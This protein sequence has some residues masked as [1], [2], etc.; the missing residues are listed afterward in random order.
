MP[1]EFLARKGRKARNKQSDPDPL[2][3]SEK[4]EKRNKRKQQAEMGE[5]SEMDQLKKIK[6][7]E[8]ADPS[9]NMIDFT[10]ESD[11]KVAKMQ[12]QSKKAKKVEQ[13]IADYASDEEQNEPETE[14]AEDD[15]FDKDLLESAEQ[16]DFPFGS[17]EDDIREAHFDKDGS[18]SEAS[19]IVNEEEDEEDLISDEDHQGDDL[20]TNI[21]AKQTT[22]FPSGQTVEKDVNVAP[23]IAIVQTRIQEVLQILKNFKQRRDPELSRDDYMNQLTEDMCLYYGYSEYLMRKLLDLFPPM[24]CSTFLEANEVPRPVTI[25]TNTLKTRRRDLAQALIQRGV[26]LDPV[27]KWSKVGLTVFDSAV[28]IGATPEYM[29]G[30]YMLQAASS[31]LPVMAL[32]PQENERIL[33]MAS[34]PGGKTTYIG[35]LMRNTGCIFANDANKDRCKGLTANVHR[36]GLTNV[37]VCNHDGRKFPGVIGGFDRVLLDAPCSGTGV[38][39]KDPAV[40][41][42]KTEE[43]FRLLSHLQK[44]LILAAIDSVDANSKTG[45]YIVYSTCSIMVEENE[46]VVSYALRRRPNIK[47]VSTGLEFGEEGFANFRGRVF[48]PSLN[49]TRRYYPHTH[50]MDGFFVAKFKKMSNTVPATA[51][52]K[53]VRESQN[54]ENVVEAEEPE[55][56]EEEDQQFMREAMDSKKRRRDRQH[57]I[58]RKPK[59][60]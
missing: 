4:R 17:D 56:N 5:N 52:S 3:P 58:K 47:L 27:G 49:L 25:R 9:G 13:R 48:H 32:A 50:N 59:K 12:R 24:E 39:S 44:E 55:F 46:D 34:A 8:A 40:K 54:K 31:F 33:D 15:E 60:E 6:F 37:V 35:A 16:E 22:V 41:L 10:T 26:N 36:M 30:Q 43:D 21:A 7:V 18:D 51:E 45:G 23:D 53:P 1:N 42:N 29:S 38:I 57:G 28:P 14:F 19:F 2:L 11:L 20:E